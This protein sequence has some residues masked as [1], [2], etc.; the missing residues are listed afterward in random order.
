MKRFT[1]S[2]NETDLVR[3]VQSVVSRREADVRLL[4]TIGADQ[5]VDLHS[6]DLVQLADRL[7]DLC[8]VGAGVNDEGQG[9]VLLDLLHRLVRRQRVAD[10]VERNDVL[11]LHGDAVARL[12]GRRL[13]VGVRAAELGAGVRLA[14]GHLHHLG[15]LRV[16]RRSLL[17]GLLSSGHDDE[18]ES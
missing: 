14:G 2:L 18:S 13:A 17:G 10:H 7:L 1:S 15:R 4:Q 16:L 3:G 6:L 11:R 9:V 5:G 8:L 12:S